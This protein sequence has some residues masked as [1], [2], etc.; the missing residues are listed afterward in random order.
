MNLA[1]RPSFVTGKKIIQKNQSTKNKS[2]RKLKN[3]KARNYRKETSSR[4]KKNSSSQIRFIYYAIGAERVEL[5]ENLDYLA[6]C[7]FY[8]SLRVISHNT[9][10]NQQTHRDKNK[11]VGNANKA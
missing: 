2:K 10:T 8:R 4:D 11:A 5:K 9:H 1:S 6:H 7:S 3:E